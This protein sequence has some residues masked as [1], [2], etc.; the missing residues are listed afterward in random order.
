MSVMYGMDWPAGLTLILHTP[1]GV[2]TAA[3]TLVEYLRSKFNYVEVIIPTLSMSAGTMMSLAADRIVMGRQSQMGPIDPQMP[4]IGRTVSARAIVDQFDRAK[5]EVKQDISNAHVW[6]AILQSLGPALLQEAQN[7]LDYGESMVARWLARYMFRDRGNAEE[8]GKRVA[9][10]FNDASLHKSHGRRIDRDE[11]RNVGVIIEDL[12]DDQG[13]QDAVLTTYHVTTITA[14][15]SPM[16]KFMA[17]NHGRRFVKNLPVLAP[18]A[19]PPQAGRPA[20]QP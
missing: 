20:T 17:S 18:T 1:G 4:V 16:T 10:H 7:A 5:T 11:A 8:L 12:E 3:E 6:A 13:L 19:I 9:A 15:N 14:E 2:T